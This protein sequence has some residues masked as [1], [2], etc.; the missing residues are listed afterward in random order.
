MENNT[1]YEEEYKALKSSG[2]FWE[3]YPELSGVWEEDKLS[4][5]SELKQT[6]QEYGENE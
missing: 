4:F 6:R 5:I 2:M 1:N 3:F